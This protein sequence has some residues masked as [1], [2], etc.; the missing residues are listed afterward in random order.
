MPSSVRAVQAARMGR[1]TRRPEYAFNLKT[2]PFLLQPFMIAPVLAGE[3]LKNL[4]LQSRV[5]SDPIKNPLIG[6][7]KEYYFFYVKLRDFVDRDAFMDMLID[8]NK[9]MT[10][11]NSA[12]N[13]AHNHTSAARID[14][15]KRCLEMVTNEYFRA[16]GET[17]AT[18]AGIIDTL[19]VVSTNFNGITDSAILDSAYTRPDVNVDLNANATIT[20]SE[21]DEALREWQW[22]R[23][24]GVTD[25]SY[26]DYLGYHGIKWQEDEPHVPELVRYVRDWTYPTNTVNPASGQPS[27]AV[28][29]AITERADK[30]RFFREP[31]FLFGVTVTRPKVY[32]RNVDGNGVDFMDNALHWLNAVLDDDPHTSMMKYLTATGPLKVSATAYW[33]DWKDLFMYGDQFVNYDITAASPDTNVVALPTAAMQKRYP[34]SADLDGLFAAIAPANKVKED[35]KVTLAVAT[36]LRDMSAQ[37]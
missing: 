37:I 10:A 30:D 4:L 19:P 8:P 17:Y 13:L 24:N 18:A 20:A 36:R 23:S 34:A 35:G 11:Y 7:W 6:W 31:G 16:E 21:V 27:S 33:V 9:S 29:W 12:V 14:Y 25:V 5:V 22:L 2:R 26:Q 15:V 1:T 3:T 28:S 32:L